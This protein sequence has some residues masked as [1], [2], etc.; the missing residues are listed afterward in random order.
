[1]SYTPIGLYNSNVVTKPVYL[2]CVGRQTLTEA[3][4]ATLD[5]DG[6]LSAEALPDAAADFTTFDHAMPY[7]RTVTAVCSAAQTGNMIIT[8]TNI[9]DVVITETIALT[10]DTP[11]ESTKAFKTVTNINLPIKAGSET[12]NVGWGDKIGIPFMLGDA[13]DRPM[14]EATL[15][16]V[17]E[18]TAPAITADADELEKNLIDLNSNLN[19]KEVCIYYWM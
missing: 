9:N 19:G 5:A 17:I 15:D 7:A 13:A 11:V 16:G 12:I 2:G 14:I 10:S 4:A 6:L 18:T 1:M 3:Q 8:G